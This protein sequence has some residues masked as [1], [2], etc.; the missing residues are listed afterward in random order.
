[1]LHFLEILPITLT[2]SYLS[3]WIPFFTHQLNII[4]NFQS[5][6]Y[7]GS[8]SHSV[9]KKQTTKAHKTEQTQKLWCNRVGIFLFT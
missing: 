5:E 2:N 7:K 4:G 9:I 1:M 3:F 6:F 8:G